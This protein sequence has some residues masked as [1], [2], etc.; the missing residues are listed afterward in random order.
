MSVPETPHYGRRATALS[1]VMAMSLACALVPSGQPP[2]ALPAITAASTA[3]A[4]PAPTSPPPT[5]TNPPPTTE[6]TPTLEPPSGVYTDNF[7]SAVLDPGWSWVRENPTAWTLTGR[8]GWL[9]LDTAQG[10]LLFAGGDAP[11]L[12]RAAPE[13]D[14][15]A[16]VLLD[17][18]PT[19]DF[20][21]AGLILYQDDD[22]FVALS[23]AFCGKG[24][25]LGDGVYMDDDQRGMSGG[26]PDNAVSGLPSAGPIYLKL[27]RQGTL[28]TGYWSAD[29]SDWTRVAETHADLVEAR[30]G[31]Y[32]DNSLPGRATVPA[33]FDQFRVGP[34]AP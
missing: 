13:G 20:Q 9:F 29:G 2:T 23:R 10:R 32:A 21:S 17:M 19:E 22:H 15:E 24:A 5:P 14:L 8:P 33:Y 28:I 27:V 11:L 4:P 3:T 16:V 7:E 18:H 1:L 12:L 25:C 26:F 30:I 31:L 6:P 34:A